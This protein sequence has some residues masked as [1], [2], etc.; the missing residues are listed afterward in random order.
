[1][2]L[3]IKTVRAVTSKTT[4]R[5]LVL[6]NGGTQDGNNGVIFSEAVWNNQLPQGMSTLETIGCELEYE[7][8]KKGE[9]FVNRDA[10]EVTVEDD[11]VLVKNNSISVIPNLEAK[12][13]ASVSKAVMASFGIKTQAT[14]SVATKV[15]AAPVTE[16]VDLNA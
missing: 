1:M 4:G 7:F 16:N 6:I 15:I 2:K 5:K 3:T 8:Y 11:N 12:I 13:A 14:A 9:T 10:E